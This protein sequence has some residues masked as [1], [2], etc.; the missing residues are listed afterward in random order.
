MKEKRVNLYQ[1]FNDDEA[2]E[3]QFASGVHDTFSI[4]PLFFQTG[5]LTIKGY[6]S[7]FKTYRLGIPN[8]EVEE[9]LMKNLISVYPYT[10]EEQ[11][12]SKLREMVRSLKRGDA[13]E[14]MQRLQNYLAGIPFTITQDVKELYFENNLFIIFNMIGIYSDCEVATS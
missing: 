4:L 1:Y 10:N 3:S 5:Y 7:D 12:F 14:F 9:G 11:A 8:K 13:E 2:D 6:N